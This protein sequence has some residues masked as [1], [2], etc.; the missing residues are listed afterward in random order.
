[1]NK[2]ANSKNGGGYLQN[3]AFTLTELI[4]V[5]IILGIISLLAFPPILNAIRSTKGK[6]SDASKEILY[7]AVGL[8]VSDNI[9]N[10]P[11]YNGNKYCVTVNELIKGEYLPTTVYDSVTG[12]EIPQDSKIEINIEND[13]YS[14]N[15]NNECKEYYKYGPLIKVLLGQYNESNTN[16][17]VKDTTSENIYYY[18][19]TNGEVSNNFLWYGG[20]QWRVIEFDIE[21]NTLT[22]IT[23]QPL[24]LI[25]PASSVWTTEKEYNESYLNQWLNE[26]FWN[27]LDNSIQNNIVDN[28]FNVGIYGETIS[29]Q[30]VE[31]IKT[32][33]KVGLLDTKQYLRAG[34][35]DSFL[36]IKD[37]FWLGNLY[38]SSQIRRVGS[39]G[40][41]YMGDL[42][43]FAGIRPV[44][45]I[46]DIIVNNGDGN[47]TSSY[48][49]SDKA[50]DTSE[51]QVGEYISVPYNGNDNACG[52]DNKCLFRVV[53]KD[54]DSIKVIL[55]G[56]LPNPSFYGE[57]PKITTNHTIYTPLNNFANNIS[58][59]YRYT[60]NKNFYIW[61]YP[62]STSES[63][64][65]KDVQKEI[66]SANVGLPT[67]GEMFTC[68]DIDITNDGVNKT[69]V[70][71]NTI[72]NPEAYNGLWVM[73]RY[74][75]TSVS[76]G[77][78]HSAGA[79]GSYP[80]SPSHNYKAG[81]RPV[82][83]LK[84]NLKIIAGDGTAQNPYTL[85]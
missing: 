34:E 13:I 58:N 63:G 79:L 64:N 18:K 20:H 41:I 31:K 29:E 25:Q 3:N 5:V 66:L 47:L 50:N 54:N 42:T 21:K 22:L 80:V 84:N 26:Y 12:N 16:G 78:I 77:V 8:Y 28:T 83:F 65:Y 4:G 38:N 1:M 69:F 35:L 75:S 45:K 23:Q 61:Y 17:L 15:L 68:N 62:Y 44:I 33:K 72:E 10:Y 19:G 56:L 6:I 71:I 82:I 48:N 85:K 52:S 60:G 32:V 36:D 81:V 14:Y 73:N 53:S 55:N 39:G 67:M 43:F 74:V 49:N 30:N 24:V 51:I 40:T 2:I 11:K 59:N 46:S 76:V 37:E 57:T 7:N 9:N 27:S 70:D